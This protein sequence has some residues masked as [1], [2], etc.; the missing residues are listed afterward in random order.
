MSSF[1]Y[2]NDQRSSYPPSWYAAS[3]S[4]DQPRSRLKGSVSCEV[5]IIGAGFT[6]LSTALHLAQ[7]GFQV[8]VLDAHRV[9]FGASGR[10]GG[11]VGSGWN[12]SQQKLEKSMGIDPARRL[13]EMSNDAKALTRDLVKKHAPEAGY[14]SGVATAN[15][16]H[17]D[18]E[19]NHLDAEYL[20]H[21]YGYTEMECL[22]QSDMASVIKSDRYK[23]GVIDWGAGHLHPLRYAIG[24]ARAAEAAGAVIHE[25][26]P[27]IRIDDGS[28]NILH[29]DRGQIKAEYVVHATN[30]YHT[31]LNKLQAARVMPINNFLVATEP[32][33]NPSS[34]LTKNIAVADNRFVLNYYRLSDDNRLIFGGGESYG[35]RFPRDL[36]S[37]VRKPLTELFPQL[38]AVKLTH[39]WGGTLGITTTRLPMLALTGTKQIVA[40][41]YSGH[42]VA[43]AGFAGLVIAETI[44]GTTERFTLLE[45]L[46]TPSFPGG[47]TLR[48]PIM[49][50]AMTWFSLRDKL[51]I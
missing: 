40:A 32:L 8:M 51:G 6:G 48:S 12:Q 9:G 37:K 10:N 1:L 47:Q 46:P 38:S 29:T 13:W 27:V 11:Q 22:T 50:L 28:P 35:A 2:V 19:Q 31:S 34:I 45:K 26:S 21:S 3:T 4:K 33:E 17:S 43:L 49:T 23:G 5:C 15:F 42:G 16:S 7:K 25:S 14:Q 30:G 18:T 36:F 24:L 44:A 41:G 20:A 39:A